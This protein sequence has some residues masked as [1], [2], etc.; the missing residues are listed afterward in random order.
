MQGRKRKASEPC[1][2]EIYQEESSIDISAE[3]GGAS[4]ES[5]R[6]E[7]EDDAEEE[8]DLS[9]RI[10]RNKV[11]QQLMEQNRQVIS[12][13]RLTFCGRSQRIRAARL[14]ERRPRA[15]MSARQKWRLYVSMLDPEFFDKCTLQGE[16]LLSHT[17]SG[18]ESRNGGGSSGGG[19]GR[20]SLRVS[21]DIQRVGLLRS[22]DRAS[23][24]YAA[25]KISE[26]NN[27]DI[28]ELFR[29]KWAAKAVR[30]QPLHTY[31]QLRACAG[32]YAR[33]CVTLKLVK[34]Q[35]VCE[36][37]CLL[38]L[39][40]EIEIVQAF[41]GFWQARAVSSTV[42][43]KACQLKVLVHEAWTFF[44]V[45]E[46]ERGKGK[47][48]EVYEYIL[49]VAS[50]EKTESRRLT[51]GRRD[52]DVRALEGKLFLPDD[53]ELCT[54]TASGKL[55]GLMDS[56]RE[57]LSLRG[58]T[59]LFDRYRRCPDL[60]RKWNINLMALLLLTAG[61]QR[62][63]VFGQL[64]CPDDLDL[65]AM[66]QSLTGNR[67]GSGHS[68]DRSEPDGYFELGVVLEKRVRSP[69]MPNVLFPSFTFRFVEFHCKYVRCFILEKRGGAGNSAAED[70]ESDGNSGQADE[71]GPVET[72]A[73]AD[74]E[75]EETLLLH[76]ERA[77]PITGDQVRSTWKRFLSELDPELSKV[78]PMVLRASFATYMIHL[79]R[80]GR[81]FRGL[82]EQEFMDRLAAL[83]N[84][85]AEMLANVYGGCDLDDYRST[86][87]EMMRVY[88]H[89]GGDERGHEFRDLFRNEG[90][91]HLQMLHR[92]SPVPSNI[93]VRPCAR[94]R[95][96][97]HHADPD[98]SGRASRDLFSH[99]D[100]GI[101]IP[102]RPSSA[103][104][105]TGVLPLSRPLRVSDH[106][107][108]D[109]SV[110]STRDTFSF[111]EDGAFRSPIRP[112]SAPTDTGACPFSRP[113]HVSN[114][115]GPNG[116]GRAFRDLLG[117]GHSRRP[118]LSSSE[119]NNSVVR[120]LAHPLRASDHLDQGERGRAFR[121]LFR[122]EDAGHL[123]RHPRPSSG[124]A[125]SS[126]LPSVPH[127]GSYANVRRPTSGGLRLDDIECDLEND[128]LT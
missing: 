116:R 60:V 114:H 62:P 16:N 101:Q 38:R 93:G 64:R 48:R 2:S 107:G 66:R 82:T 98:G 47:S 23:Q 56:A 61:G 74:L 49:S 45:N 24:G 52:V 25:L 118:N 9:V 37:G 10:S 68:G 96:V 17:A 121:G 76:T 124:F 97:D 90:D 51:S 71:I 3:L 80:V 115:A 79:Y 91:G 36:R 27:E 12:G 122:I 104:T 126:G 54:N 26:E 14:D 46:D 117:D 63:Q 42:Y 92:T 75:E 78:T 5:A 65:G 119:P 43:S 89:T 58:K 83:M 41:V 67:G 8:A 33:F 87:N 99:E 108:H 30:G 111:E 125:S 40:A 73:H 105:N 77:I 70:G 88:D 94:P 21:G 95:L 13:R 4:E 109:G 39:V 57:T 84:T 127:R 15:T 18:T 7:N 103:P 44:G 86:A 50:A 35:D 100:E 123:Q 85:S 113:P 102:S 120:P 72:R 81:H 28:S 29:K 20:A 59:G 106:A 32:Q 69:R 11:L 110:L 34:V 22:R 19:G 53:F 112:S 31:A 6:R 55:S 128:D 1:G